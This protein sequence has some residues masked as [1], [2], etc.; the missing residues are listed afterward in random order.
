AAAPEDIRLDASKT[1][2]ER[3]RERMR[4]LVVVV[5]VT[6]GTRVARRRRAR[7]DE[8]GAAKRQIH[9][10]LTEEAARERD[11]GDDGERGEAR[12]SVMHA[13][14]RCRR[15]SCRRSTIRQTTLDD[16]ATARAVLPLRHL[17]VAHQT[18]A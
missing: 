13:P 6:D 5:R 4:M 7:R 18:F 14:P 11:R 9:V 8:A 12:A 3:V 16:R 17:R 1:T 2:R 15:R 10:H